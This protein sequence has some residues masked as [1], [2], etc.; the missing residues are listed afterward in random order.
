MSATHL[1][2][3]SSSLYAVAEVLEIPF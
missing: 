2:G 3:T 1:P